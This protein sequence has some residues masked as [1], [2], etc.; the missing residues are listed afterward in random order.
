VDEQT[1][2]DVLTKRTYNQRREIA[3]AYERR[4]KKDMISA[5]K[6]ALSGSLETVILGLMKSTA[7]YDA[8]E[9]KASIKVNGI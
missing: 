3:F 7:Q 2:T 6:G 8:S 4:A 9:I 5:L 1:I